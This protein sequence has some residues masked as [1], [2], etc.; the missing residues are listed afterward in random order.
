MDGYIP[1]KTSNNVPLRQSTFIGTHEQGQSARTNENSRRIRSFSLT[2]APA[3]ISTTRSVSHSAPSR[4]SYAF[5]PSYTSS[6]SLCR[7]CRDASTA[8]L[9]TWPI[10][11]LSTHA[12][13]REGSGFSGAV[14]GV[15]CCSSS[16]HQRRDSGPFR[17]TSFC[18]S[19]SLQNRVASAPAMREDGPCTPTTADEPKRLS[20]MS[21][22]CSRSSSERS[23]DK[24]SPNRWPSSSS[25]AGWIPSGWKSRASAS[26]ASCMRMGCRM[27]PTKTLSNRLFASTKPKPLRRSSFVLGP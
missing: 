25:V 16:N 11:G 5:A 19:S 14:S 22:L 13:N 27:V 7:A 8:L 18:S 15:T 21:L 6:R 9:S 12:A 4:P 26:A 1:S 10:D 23:A 3:T 24:A 20:S 2:Y 17:S